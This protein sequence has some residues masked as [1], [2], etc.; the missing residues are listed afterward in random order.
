MHKNLFEFHNTNIVTIGNTYIDT[1]W[2]SDV[3]RVSPE[4]PV[5]VAHYKASESR[6]A[7][8]GLIAAL[9]KKLSNSVHHKLLTTVLKDCIATGKKSSS[10]LI[11]LFSEYDINEVE[12][13]PVLDNELEHIRII[14]DKE[15]LLGINK[16]FNTEL[17]L[18]QVEECNTV[19]LSHFKQELLVSEKIIVLY[20][21]GS[22]IINQ[23]ILDK[24]YQDPNLKKRQVIYTSRDY[25]T[26]DK[27][28]ENPN[29]VKLLNW[30]VLP[31]INNNFLKVFQDYKNKINTKLLCFDHKKNR[32]VLAVPES[33]DLT[34]KD[35]NVNVDNIIGLQEGVTAALALLCNR[36]VFSESSTAII[37]S[38]SDYIVKHFGQVVPCNVELQLYY[39]E[40]LLGNIC[41]F[42]HS[43]KEIS[44]AK[45]AGEK[46]VFANGCFD[47]LHI[48]HFKYLNSARQKGDR[49]IVA[50]NSDCSVKRLKGE[51][52]PINGLYKRLYMLNQLKCVDWVLP[53]FNDTPCDLLKYI[54]P[55]VLVKGGDYTVD[56]IVGKEIVESYGGEACIVKHDFTEVSSTKIIQNSLAHE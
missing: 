35:L 34:I 31:P 2:Y 10:R 4:A 49:L 6:L 30:C 21:D 41:K 40:K 36:D 32:L 16:T 22:G 27:F 13:I 23:N 44:Q 26:L 15:Q 38:V 33:Q 42:A 7:G 19:V 9:I 8:A 17:T 5:P 53:F 25:G 20:D 48:G 47:V 29:N 54:Q 11:A 45:L 50:I 55:D 3:N 43:L 39:A 1:Y 12:F 14:N 51:A 46:I 28:L 56:G 24:L 37:S 52:R 18:S